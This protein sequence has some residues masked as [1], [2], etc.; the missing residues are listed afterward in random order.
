M[1]KVT[2]MSLCVC[3]DGRLAFHF[4]VRQLLWRR[5]YDYHLALQAPASKSAPPT[6]P[7]LGLLTDFIVIM[8]IMRRSGG[9]ARRC[10]A[11]DAPRP[12]PCVTPRR[13]AP[14]PS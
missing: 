11:D 8:M 1:P 3:E 12:S 7:R 10:N 13:L 4:P 5:R 9:D 6:I 2:W 14:L